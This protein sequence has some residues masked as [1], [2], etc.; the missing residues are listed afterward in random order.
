MTNGN[1]IRVN[2]DTI[3]E[4]KPSVDTAFS[5]FATVLLEYPVFAGP[6]GAVTAA[7]RRDCPM[8]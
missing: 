2:M 5:L 8:M 1:K 4:N 3:A 7:L 6:V